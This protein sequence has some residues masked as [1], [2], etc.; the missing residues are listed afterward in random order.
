MPRKF[1]DIVRQSILDH[2]LINSPTTKP[3]FILQLQHALIN[4]GFLYLK[5]HGVDNHIIDSLISYIP[6]LFALPQHKIR[7]ANSEHFL[8]YS[9]IGMELTKGKVKRGEQFGFATP[10]VSRWREDETPEELEY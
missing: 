1:P 3:Q 2:S 4:V 5:N 9:K 8:G 7:M 10:H 6:Q